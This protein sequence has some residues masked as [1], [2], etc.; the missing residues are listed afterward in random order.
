[1]HER[2]CD[3]I[4][5]FKQSV[6]EDKLRRSEALRERVARRNEIV[7]NINN[8]PLA[9]EEKEEELR[10]S[11]RREVNYMKEKLRNITIRDFDCIKTIGTGAFGIVR[12]CRRKSDD[13]I[14]AVKQM[15]KQDM[16]YKNQ[17]MHVSAEQEALKRASNDWVINLECTFQDA[18]YLYMVMSYHAGGDLMTHLM[19]KDTFIE[20][21]ALFYVA[22]LTEAIDYIHTALHIIHRD[23]KPDVF[24]IKGHI[25]LL[26]FGLCKYESPQVEPLPSIIE[27]EKTE[28]SADVKVE[29]RYHPRRKELQSIVGT[30]DYMAPEVYD[31]SSNYNHK[32]D[33]WSCGI[34]MFE[35]L[36]GGPPF[37]D[38]NHDAQVTSHR[39]CR[40]QQYFVMPHDPG[41]SEHARDLM[42]HLICHKEDRYTAREI[43][44]HPF[45]KGMDFS[46]LRDME[47]PLK[48]TVN[49]PTDT[50]NFDDFNGADEHF[51]LAEGPQR[52]VKVADTQF[53]RYKFRRDPD[54]IPSKSSDA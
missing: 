48:P 42:R 33:W 4:A 50:Q 16:V 29:R 38:E 26:D 51:P 46:R 37:S 39:V 54:L 22:E 40:W 34:I 41:V 8:A 7:Q 49:D 17:V 43:R 1:M 12:L 23:I 3:K 45:F 9:S 20:E 30:P 53:L 21:E 52:Y 31:S 13:K 27:E 47:P 24:D 35:M 25:H 44:I 15:G 6:V 28:V 19:R 10:K 18:D 5:L 36:F 14:F 11:E 32:V 2:S